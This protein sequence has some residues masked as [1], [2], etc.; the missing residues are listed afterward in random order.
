MSNSA[1]GQGFQVIFILFI[2]L[3]TVFF[4]HSFVRLSMLIIKKRRKGRTG[5]V[6]ESSNQENFA[7]PTQPIRVILARDEEEGTSTVD[8][9]EIEEDEPKNLPPPPPA[10]GLWRGSMVR[11][12]VCDDC[13]DAAD[14]LIPES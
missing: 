10:Y 5:A 14:S 4:C 6:S 11:L 2:L 1:A 13:I 3:F 9:N 7:R 8:G 12:A